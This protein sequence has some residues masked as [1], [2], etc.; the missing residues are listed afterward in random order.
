[1]NTRKR[2]TTWTCA[3]ILL[4]LTAGAPAVAD[5]TE[6]LLVRPAATADNKPNLLFILDTS[7][8]MNTTEETVEPYTFTQ[9]YS[10]NCDTARVYWTD[11]DV[12]P[13]CDGSNE[14]YIDKDNFFCQ[15]ALDQMQGIGSAAG[16]MIQ[17]RDGGPNGNTSGAKMWQ[18]IA[19]G[20]NSEPVECEGDSGIHG[21]GRPTHLWAKSGANLGDWYTDN[22][23]EEVPWGSAPRNLGY[24]A[25]DGNYLNWRTSPVNANISRID[26]VKSVVSAVL[27]SITGVNVGI[28]L[29]SVP[30][31]PPV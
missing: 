7:G 14:R 8:S 16:T 28:M 11:V 25:Y 30:E 31:Y 3:A 26:I 1:M 27:R 15:A 2:H 6:L 22:P 24:V 19:P 9:E 13:V 10:G 21:D 5:D 4:A 17:Y 18:T 23:D 12:V 29:S 20:Y